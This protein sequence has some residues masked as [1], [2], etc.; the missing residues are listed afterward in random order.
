MFKRYLSAEVL[1]SRGSALQW[2]PLLAVPLVVLTALFSALASPT[3]DATGVLGWQSMFIT[4]MYAPL[5]ALFAAIPE[6]REVRT[7]GGGTLWRRINAHYEQASRYLAVLSSLAIFHVL[8]FGLS[9]AIVALQGRANHQ[10]LV[11]AGLYSFLGAI[12]IAGLAVGC[13]R[14]CGLVAAL[15]GG[16]VWQEIG[17]LPSTVEGNAWWAF[18]PAWPMRL[19]LPALRIHQNSVPLD[20]GDPLLQEGP[21]PAALLCLVLAAVGTCAAIF[22]PRRIRP[23]RLRLRQGGTA[24]DTAAIT[25]GEVWT[26]TATP[27]AAARSK[28]PGAL[29]GLHRAASSPLLI[30]CLVLSIVALA[31]IALTYPADYVHGFFVFALLPVGAGVLPCIVWP[32]LA[33]AWPLSYSESRHS[34]NALLIWIFGAVVF[35][36]TAASLASISAGSSAPA[37]LGRLPLAVGVGFSIAVIS[38]CIV[39]RFGIISA[40]A[41]TIM[42]SIVSVTLG[43]DVL[44]KTYLWL[45]AFSAWPINADTP[46]R[47][48]VAA[49]LTLLIAAVGSWTAKQ[50]LRTKALQP[51][52]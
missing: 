43:G 8:N 16:I 37:V 24:E 46:A 7:R 49:F 41:L 51:M 50:L 18:P 29:I 38:L 28:L 23:L 4:G 19:M 14:R 5:I 12:G 22:T 33:A 42:G 10:L 1:R 32:L 17:T 40:L 36:C 52:D 48:V 13:S 6:R 20:P 21:L 2:L 44:A 39:V 3:Q 27:R 35:V 31:V 47:Y 45:I 25:T 30:G 15:A 34:P 11:V 9:W 26:P